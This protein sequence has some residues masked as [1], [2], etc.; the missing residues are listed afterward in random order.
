MR[1]LISALVVLLLP[2]A[3]HATPGCNMIGGWPGAQ[4]GLPAQLMIDSL[5]CYGITGTRGTPVVLQ[6]SPT[7]NNTLTITGTSPVALTVG[8]LGITT[9]AFTVNS[10]AANSI[11]GVIISSQS[12]GNGVNISATGETNVPLAINGAGSGQISLGAIST[13]TIDVYR[14]MNFIGGLGT[15]YF[16]ATSGFTHVQSA[17]IASGTLTLPTTN[18]TLV[19]KATADVFTNKT[20]DTGG[21]GNSFSLNSAAFNTQPQAIKALHILSAAEVITGVQFN[22]GNTDFIIT[23]PS[24]PSGYTRYSIRNVFIS[25]A[26]ASLNPATCGLFTANSAGGLALVTSGTAVTVTATADS[27]TNNMQVLSPVNVN[28][29]SNLYSALTSGQ[30]YFRVQTA[31]SLPATASITVNYSWLP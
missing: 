27:T 18:D 11:T 20:F 30:I 1:K 8:Q 3:A 12:A 22:T 24:P 13:G 17:S 21:T 16:G 6:T 28:T 4:Y 25:G 31:S 5:P 9:P 23:L 10:S 2:A 14:S 29:M 26:S 19:G 15:N 7:V